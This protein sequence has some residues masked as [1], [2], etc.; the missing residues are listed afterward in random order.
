MHSPTRLSK[1]LL[2]LVGLASTVLVLVGFNEATTQRFG[3]HSALDML[4]MRSSEDGLL[5]Q[6]STFFAT[7]GRCSG[8]HGH[9]TLGLAMVNESGTDVNVADDWRSTM[10]ANS[11][12]D[13][14]FLAKAEHEVLVN[15]GHQVAIENKCLSCHA[16]LGMHEERLLDHPPFTLAMLDTS[17]MGQEGVSCLACHQQIPDSAGRFF[18]GELHFG[19]E[20]AN[21]GALVYGP[22]ADDEINSAIMEF[23]VGFKPGYGEHIQDGRVCAGCHSLITETLDLDGNETGGEFIEQATWH[24][25]KNSNYTTDAN[26]TCRGCHMPR[27]ED[28]IILAS[29]YA[30][31]QGHSPFGLHHLAG[32]NTMM[33]RLMKANRQQLGI[34]ATDTQF[35]STIARSIR[36]LHSSVDLSLSITGRTADTAFI[37]A[38]LINLAGH[39]FPSGYPSRRA[40]VQV[41][42]TNE[43]GD[44][45]FQSGR[46]D[47]TNEVFG[48]DT[49]YEPHYDVITQAD[50]VQLYE[51]VMGDVN[52]NVTTVL[53]RAATAIKDN[54]LV[55]QGFSTSHS[56]YDTTRIEGVPASDLDFNH[57]ALG[58]EGNGGD[59][60]H[61]H[62]ALNGYSGDLHVQARVY[63]QPV[64]PLWNAEMFSNHSAAI[65]TFRTMYAEADGTPE[66][67]AIDSL[68][69]ISSG[70]GEPSLDALRV[71]P[72][73]SSDGIIHIPGSS[74][75]RISVFDVA[76]RRVPVEPRYR[77]NTWTCRLPDAEGVYHIVIA[78]ASGDR[79]LRVVRS[80]ER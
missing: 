39:K 51:L 71:Y 47:G 28:P 38:R 40:I 53:E 77:S 16:P 26:T 23:F 35:D 13:P 5:V 30:F 15:P 50:Q 20:P 3:P 18:S 12:R 57:D 42:A 43:A 46:W 62:I 67:V 14:F 34:P 70:L 4:R 32:G 54:R 79:L 9:D 41:I 19:P 29:E 60:V 66:L 48:H 74:I 36:Q 37:E 55:P 65:D 31:L 72:N 22:Y 33:L 52:G 44:T 80:N 2:V 24:E 7:A 8:C 21:A 27:I 75:D 78:T 69:D 1:R 10:M 25:W 58:T 76:G 45:L 63:Y 49:G 64:P 56:A 17:V 11:A 68:L 6:Y 61:Y 59:I 73:P